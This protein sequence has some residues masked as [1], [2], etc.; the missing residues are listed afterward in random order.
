M[1]AAGAV[2]LTTGLLL[3]GASITPNNETNTTTA[4]ATTGVLLF[5][6]GFGL[7]LWDR[8]RSRETRVNLV[9][10]AFP[11]GLPDFESLP[12]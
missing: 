2:L 1:G 11:V 8:A 6:T 7:I 10:E 5:A 12:P 9:D 3:L 4:E